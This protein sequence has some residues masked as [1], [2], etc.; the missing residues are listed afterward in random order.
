MRFSEAPCLGA[1]VKNFADVRYVKDGDFAAE[2]SIIWRRNHVPF[3]FLVSPAVTAP[4]AAPI[5]VGGAFVTRLNRFF[6]SA[7]ERMAASSIVARRWFSALAAGLAADPWR[8]SIAALIGAAMG[9][10]MLDLQRKEERL[11]RLWWL[12]F[13]AFVVTGGVLGSLIGG[14][15]FQIIGLFFVAGLPAMLFFLCVAIFGGAN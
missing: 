8:L 13:R 15:V 6:A 4:G 9:G 3:L 5:A 10:H 14:V 2:S 11:V 1:R 12:L 7:R